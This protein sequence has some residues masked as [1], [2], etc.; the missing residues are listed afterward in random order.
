MK[1][2]EMFA[3]LVWHSYWRFSVGV[4]ISAA[5]VGWKSVLSM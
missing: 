1:I 5:G 3:S 2:S 4:G